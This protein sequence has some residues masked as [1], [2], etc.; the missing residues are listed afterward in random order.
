M[1]RRPTQNKKAELPQRL[2]RVPR[3]APYVWVP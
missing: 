2:Q 3:D 1:Q